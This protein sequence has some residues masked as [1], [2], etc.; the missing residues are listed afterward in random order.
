VRAVNR[1]L[2]LSNHIAD[3][4]ILIRNKHIDALI[5]RKRSNNGVFVRYFLLL[6]C[7]LRQFVSVHFRLMASSKSRKKAKRN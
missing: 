1:R 6:P 7:N 4:D 2:L 5:M 3:M